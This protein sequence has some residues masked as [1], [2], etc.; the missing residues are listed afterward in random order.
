MFTGMTLGEIIRLFLPLI[1]IQFLLMIFC[2]YKLTKD[3]VKFLPKWGWALIII[4]INFFGAIFYLLV[5]RE[6][7]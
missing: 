2:L 6:R 3:K 7:D 5:G 1:I 4:F